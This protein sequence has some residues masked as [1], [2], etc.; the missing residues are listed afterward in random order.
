MVTTAAII[1]AF[2]K[3][4]TGIN[5]D[6]L[7]ALVRLV[8]S[9]QSVRKLKHIVAQADDDELGILGSLLDIVGHDG[10]VAKVKGCVNLIH[11]IE[12]RGLEMVQGKDQGEGTQRLQLWLI[13]LKVEISSPIS[14]LSSPSTC[15][16]SSR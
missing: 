8:D 5:R 2:G 9:N 13:M 6:T 11:E 4:K 1:I 15:L 12:R 10:D 7:G 14:F 3:N 16:F